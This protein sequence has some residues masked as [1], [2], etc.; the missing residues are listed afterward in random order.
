MRTVLLF[1][2]TAVL[3]GGCGNKVKRLSA[4][5]RDHYYALKVWMEDGERKA[6]LKNKTEDER[7]AWLHDNGF[8]DR[9]YQYDEAMRQAIIDGDVSDGWTYD[10]VYMA[11][12][13]PH[14]RK[15]L[16]GRKAQRSELLVYRFEVQAD[17]SVVV[18]Q[19]GSKTAH[20]AVDLYR[21]ELNVDDG[22]VT[23]STRRA[24]WQ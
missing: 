20:I 22:V 17:G 15:R 13:K 11:W 5:E 10:Q 21:I 2:L 23:E 18:W 3:L 1:A 9:F 7:N 4:V 14:E 12:G 8:W 16:T 19:P 6:Y 24:G